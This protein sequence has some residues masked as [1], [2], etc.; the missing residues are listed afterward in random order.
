MLVTHQG[1]TGCQ[2]STLVRRFDRLCWV[3]NRF[4]WNWNETSLKS[5][6]ALCHEV[7][8]TSFFARFD[9]SIVVRLAHLGIKTS[10][11]GITSADCSDGIRQHTDFFIT[12]NHFSILATLIL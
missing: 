7:F 10:Y 4:D 5:V 8:K 3:L 6:H 12:V 1:R 2:D 11:G 9:E